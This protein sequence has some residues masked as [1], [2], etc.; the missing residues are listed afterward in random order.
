MESHLGGVFQNT[1][2]RRSR[3]SHWGNYLEFDI[4]AGRGLRSRPGT[5][6]QF[7]KVRFDPFLEPRLRVVWNRGT[8]QISA[9]A[10]IYHQEII[11]LNDRRD[12][13]S[14]FTVWTRIER[15]NPNIED[16]RQGQ[17]QRASHALLG[18]RVT[19]VPWLD[20][21]VE[22]FYKNLSNLFIS[23]WT[24]FPELTTRLQPASGRVHGFDL[25]A[26]V[27]AGTFYG[28]VNYGLSSTRYRAEQ[29]TLQL[30]YGEERMRFRPGHDRRHQINLVAGTT[31]LGLDTSLRW[32]LGSG[33]PFS[34]AIGFDGFALIDDVHRMGDVEDRRRVIYERP[35]NAVLPTYHRLDFS[36]ARSFRL[37]SSDVSLQGSV[38]NLYDR[39][40]LFYLDVFTLT[41]VDQM[42][43][44][45]TLAVKVAFD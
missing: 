13:A 12:A 5:G 18:Y 7:Y 20:V 4:D 28:F 39:R 37:G 10:G 43:L 17:P 8:H 14:I 32:E 19:P 26:E 41:R 42:P 38:I 22:G 3:V 36:V 44:V 16:V 30:W 9:A 21:S 33:L 29:A 40:N 31:V 35:Y 45:P 25:R 24:A 2:I 34:R 15:D 27:R 23:E 6:A 11:G 1:E